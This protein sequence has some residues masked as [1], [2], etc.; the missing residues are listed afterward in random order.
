MTTEMQF[1][2]LNRGK[3]AACVMLTERRTAMQSCKKQRWYTV[4]I[5][6][7]LAKQWNLTTL[8]FLKNLQPQK[9]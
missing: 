8:D 2:V 3:E 7:V 1:R 5:L 4:E 9:K 6:V